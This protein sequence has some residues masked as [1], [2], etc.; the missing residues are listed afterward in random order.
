MYEFFKAGFSPYCSS[1]PKS[2]EL[3][4]QEGSSVLEKSHRGLTEISVY[5][6]LLTFNILL[7]A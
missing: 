7:Q 3:K 1:S 6:T 2:A 5:F 4:Q